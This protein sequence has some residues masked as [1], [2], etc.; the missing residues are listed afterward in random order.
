M[1]VT[2][3]TLQA[4]RHL[5]RVLALLVGSAVAAGAQPAPETAAGYFVTEQAER[6]AVVFQE[7]CAICHGPTLA[8]GPAGPALLRPFFCTDWAARPVRELYDFVRTQMPM[9]RP[10]ILTPEAY[11]DVV[12][13]LLSANGIEAGAAEMGAGN[14]NHLPPQEDWCRR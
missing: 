8:G 9:G 12:A 5:V 14:G 11:A 13:F 2:T 3:P 4:P 6:G 1:P 7:N 10:G